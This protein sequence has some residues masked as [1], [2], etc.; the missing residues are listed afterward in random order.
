MPDEI[1]IFPLATVLCPGVILPLHVFEQ[2][3]KEMMRYAIE[4]GGLFGL[5][6]HDNANVGKESVPEPGSIGCLAKI[7]AVMPLEEGRLNLIT[8]GIVRYKVISYTQTLPFLIARIEA[9]ADEPEHDEEL[10]RLFESL[11]KPGQELV[12]AAQSLNETGA[13]FD[14]DLPDDPEAFSLYM[15]SLL[16]VNNEVKQTFL[17]MSSTRSRL[18]RLKSLIHD[19]LAKFTTRLQMQERAKT[20][21]HGKLRQTE[22][23]GR[24]GET[25]RKGVRE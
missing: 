2:R 25:G 6:F 4:N 23:G 13:L 7:N 19:T 8:S 5:S 16:P 10:T 3:Y 21:G 14:P 11:K 9:F 20:N 15:T 12:T 22:E 1:P 17:A 24:N 18:I